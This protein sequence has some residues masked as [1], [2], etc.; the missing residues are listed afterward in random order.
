ME[1][2]CKYGNHPEWTFKIEYKDHAIHIDGYRYDLSECE[3]IAFSPLNEGSFGYGEKVIVSYRG[4]ALELFYKPSEINVLEHMEMYCSMSDGYKE[5]RVEHQKHQK[6][7][8]I[9]SKL[10][11]ILLKVGLGLLIGLVI[12]SIIGGY[13]IKMFALKALLGIS[14]LFLVIIIT[15]WIVYAIKNRE[16]PEERERMRQALIQAEANK[17]V[18]DMLAGKPN[19]ELVKMQQ[20][21]ETKEII[22]GAVAGGIN[23]GDA[24]AVVG[25][26]I[27]KNKID[28]EKK[29]Q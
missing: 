17:R 12:L 5:R 20:K 13:E 18:Q 2:K 8:A 9:K 26:M 29:Q 6:K 10:T 28:N 25:A 24:G 19:P 7:E 4:N 3:L 27:A 11:K 22:K 23:A 1:I 21:K 14:V 16:T 15:W